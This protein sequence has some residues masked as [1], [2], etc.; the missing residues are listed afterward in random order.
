MKKVI[1]IDGPAGAGKSTVAQLVAAQLKYVYIDTGAMYRAV[2]WKILQETTAENVTNEF[3]TA[4]IN[5]IDVRLSYIEE[6]TKVEVNGQ[7]IT[8]QLKIPA[9][10]KLVSQVASIGQV[11]EKLVDLQRKMAKDG[12][13]VMDG[14][15]IASNVLPNAD[16]KIFLTASVEERAQRRF[17]EMKNKGYAVA[18][19]ELKT[20][21]AARDRADMQRKISPLVQTKDAVLLDTTAMNID[22]VVQKILSMAKN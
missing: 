7:D 14:R 19:N 2:A 13:V 1:A 6:K 12:A 11:R 18:L 8:D 16:L 5:D 21:I 20:D 22:E 10:N 3:I 15:D 4:S 9:V 17:K